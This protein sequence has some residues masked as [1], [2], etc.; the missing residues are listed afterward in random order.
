[1]LS[2]EGSDE[3]YSEG[4]YWETKCRLECEAAKIVC[5]RWVRGIA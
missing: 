4:L 1:M 2:P 3:M 5:E